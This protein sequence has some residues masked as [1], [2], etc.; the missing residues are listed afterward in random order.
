MAICRLE[1]WETEM[2]SS[3]YKRYLDIHV[4]RFLGFYIEP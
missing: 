1:K 4:Q 3:G 2:W